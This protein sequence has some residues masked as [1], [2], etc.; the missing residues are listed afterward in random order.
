MEDVRYPI[1][2]FDRSKGTHKY[3]PE[4]RKKLIE[5]IAEMP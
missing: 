2:K 5:S 3:T 1:G 4:E